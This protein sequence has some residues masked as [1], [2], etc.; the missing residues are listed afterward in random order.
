LLSS[1]HT[2]P[3]NTKDID[4]VKQ[5]AEKKAAETARKTA[6]LMPVQEAVAVQ[7]KVT[8]FVS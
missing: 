3:G 6:G 5:Y 7:T 1:T 2:V 8:E 4:N